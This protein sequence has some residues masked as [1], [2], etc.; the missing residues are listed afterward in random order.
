MSTK[1]SDLFNIFR[2]MDLTEIKA[3]AEQRFSLLIV[4][5]KTLASTLA[6]NFSQT[7]DKVGIH[8][9]VIVESPPFTDNVND[10]N[11]YDLA[12]LVSKEIELDAS[13]TNMLSRLHEAKIPAIIVIVSEAA[14]S[15]VGANLTRRYET[16]RVVLPSL[17]PDVIQED[18]VLAIVEALP[19]SQLALARHFPLLR[20]L[21]I[22]NLIEDTSRANAIYAA[23]TGLA[24]MVPVLDLPLNVADIVI[25][26][27]NQLIMAYK[28]A[29]GNGKEGEPYN[30]FVEVISVIGGGFLLREIARKL[31]GLIPVVG[32]IPKVA[33]SYAGTRV[34][35][36][37][38]Y[39]W[40]SGAQQLSS[41]ERGRFYDNALTRGR[42][43]AKKITKR[44]SRDEEQAPVLPPPT[45]KRWWQRTKEITDDSGPTK[46]LPS[47]TKNENENE[48]EKRW[49]HRFR[50]DSTSHTS[51]E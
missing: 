42:E 24:E 35:G 39:L 37:V 29:L 15:R 36:E 46:V 8:P 47:S 44:I 6:T 45:K 5:E 21:I 34:I 7:Q 31:V 13:Q 12:L 11:L 20:P 3:Q 2:E 23:S 50:R 41:V 1:F 43:L 4:G 30:L 14:L 32:I 27:K 22:H 25:L 17:E 10:L 38:V 28:V 18:F 48:N 49:W 33:V 9:W 26:T 16:A 40:A 19:N 51:S